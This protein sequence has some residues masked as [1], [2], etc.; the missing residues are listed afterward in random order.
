MKV[1]KVVILFCTVT[2][3]SNC[4]FLPSMI[5]QAKKKIGNVKED[6]APYIEEAPVFED[7]TSLSEEAPAEED[8][9]AEFYFEDVECME[10][11]FLL[12]KMNVVYVGVDN[13]CRIFVTNVPS[14]YVQVTTTDNLTVE[15]QEGGF[16]TLKGTS[17]GV[18]Q[19]T[20]SAGDYEQTYEVRVKEIPLPV[21]KLGVQNS[22]T[23]GVATFK[24][25][26]GLRIWFNDFDFDIQ[27]RILSFTI[28]RI[29]K[30]GTTQTIE[31][32]GAKWSEAA[33]ILVQQA[34]QGDIYLFE[35]IECTDS[36]ADV[37][38]ELEAIQ[39][40]NLSFRIK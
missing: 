7:S 22:G 21:A 36:E 20:V 37:I 28:T 27:Y 13:P 26:E 35:N 23:I 8:G 4:A 32:K 12:D 39:L 11:S 38:E 6:L 5:M 29:A 3:L 16:Y 24:E 19:V 2:L 15:V 40:L 14:E 17:S 31:N 30:N 34:A 9:E 33:A 25:Q 10:A 1:L 18:G